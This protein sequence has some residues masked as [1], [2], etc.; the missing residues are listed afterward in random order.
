M[1]DLAAEIAA[2]MLSNRMRI[3]LTGFS[4]GWGLFILIVLLGAGNGL[5]RG[6][7]NSFDSDTT[8]VIRLTPGTAQIAWNGLGPGRKTVLLP[9]DAD[10]LRRETKGICNRMMITNSTGQ[11]QVDVGSKHLKTTVQGVYPGFLAYDGKK[12]VEGH[13]LTDLD[14]QRLEKVCL[15]GR[16]S[17]NLLYGKGKSP[18]G[19]QV[20]ING[21]SHLVVGVYDATQGTNSGHTV[22]APFSTIQA[23]YHPDRALSQIVMVA[24]SIASKEGYDAL[25]E[26]IYLTL[27]KQKHFAPT[28]RA[29]VM[30]SSSFISYLQLKNVISM[31]QIFIWVIGLAT[32]VAGVVGISNIMLISVKE[33]TKELAVRR[34][35]GAPASS[36]ITLVLL[37]SVI[38]SLVFG[39]TGMMAGV[40]LTQLLAWGLAAAGGAG[41]FD[42]PTVDFSTI[43]AANL[44]MVL[45]GLVAGYFP[46]RNAVSIKLVE[47][48]QG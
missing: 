45:A 35:M 20:V 1:R 37:E 15:I 22:Y 25:T 33:R 24:S 27:S 18:I 21:I 19:R 31:L 5:M 4:I 26:R 23:C 10:I 42:N 44:I 16:Q 47:A 39:Y 32:L 7:A 2:S 8:C 12:I 43:M 30:C 40:G 38:V 36:I 48:L 29:A 34:A 46:A 9:E 13:D 3:A 14:I 11:V 6:I 28:D 41:L 17:A